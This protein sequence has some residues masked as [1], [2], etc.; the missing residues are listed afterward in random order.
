MDQIYQFKSFIK[1]HQQELL[2]QILEHLW[3][4]LISLAIATAMGLFLGIF[5]SKKRK[6]SSPIIGFVNAIQT[7]PSVALLGFLIPF[8]GIGV[9]PAIVALFLYA[10]LPIVRNTY[11]GI[12]EIDPAIKEAAIGMGMSPQQVLIK[13]ELP[14]AMP[15]IFAGIRTAFVI[16]VGVATLCALIAAGGLGEFIFRGLSTN[17]PHMILAGAIPAALMALFFDTL[18]SHIQKHIYKLI[19]PILITAVAS[20]LFITWYSL[21]GQTE[22]ARFVAG[23]PSEFIERGDGYLGLKEAYSLDLEVKEME[24]GL[25]YQ[26]VK[27][28]H[29]DVISGFSTDGRIEAFNLYKL[30]DDKNYF[31]PY[32]ASPII[33]QKTL[34]KHPRIAVALSELANTIS[35][36]EMARMNFLVDEKGVDIREVAMGFLKSKGF[37][38]EASLSGNPDV[39]IGSKN[40]TES[41][42]LAHIFKIIIEN[43]TGLTVDLKL[44]FGGTKLLFD[45]LDTGEIDIYPEYTGTGLLVILKPNKDV[46]IPYHKDK[47]FDFVSKEFKKQYN[48]VW[49]PPLGFNNTFALMMRKKQAESLGIQSISDLA[50]ARKK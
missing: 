41:Y 23:F 3:L 20:L 7:V 9:V 48:I 16:N 10:L 19:K 33:H 15:V 26:A 42:I 18:M 11:I 36:E 5:I 47:V 39:L 32:H 17:N 34:D 40:F 4:C 25:M 28:K 44:G 50:K 46:N 27:S 35:D 45:A 43:K 21:S 14:L 12:A 6:L 29:V 37:P 49:L 1:S 30:R 13:V 2:D 24:I 8:L 38:V 31:P 22:S